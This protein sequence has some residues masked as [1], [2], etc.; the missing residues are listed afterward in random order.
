MR[1]PNGRPIVTL[2]DWAAGV[3]FVGSRFW[4]TKH[5]YCSLAAAGMVRSRVHSCITLNTEAR[6][7]HFISIWAVAFAHD[8]PLIIFVNSGWHRAELVWNGWVCLLWPRVEWWKADLVTVRSE[9]LS[10]TFGRQ[11]W[12]ADLRGSPMYHGSLVQTGLWLGALQI[13][14]FPLNRHRH[15]HILG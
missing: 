7:G 2:W 12:R 4:L 8:Q 6:M 5:G 1:H 14:C 3:E 15:P 10:T 9:I 13:A 11:L